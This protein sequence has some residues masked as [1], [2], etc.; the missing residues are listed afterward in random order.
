[1]AEN[2]AP[3]LWRQLQLTARVVHQIGQGR[4][5]TASLEDV[6]VG[7]RPGVQA[8][9]FAVL[10]SLGVAQS[11]LK[12]LAKR[13]PPAQATAL[14][15]TALA[16]LCQRE[17]AMYDAFTLVNQAVEAAKNTPAIKLQASFINACL[18]K[19]LRERDFFMVQV[20]A[21]GAAHWNHPTW[22]IAQL[23]RDWPD[24]W[25]PILAAN[26]RQAPLTLRVN[27]RRISRE[28]YLEKLAVA[29]LEARLVCES[30]LE[31]NQAVGVH[32]LP[33]FGEGWVS[34]Q[35]S[36]AQL[37]A[38]LLLAGRKTQESFR[39]IGRAHV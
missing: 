34:V 27:T 8:L 35:D 7:M 13:A 10:R 36:A 37:A 17:G 31:L 25:Q 19:F 6:A 3:P 11:L 33:G 21:D 30:G 22:W 2:C 20:E 16:L 23:Q 18:R 9:S 24:Q 15:C 5:G 28:A 12:L 4:S 39:E 29:G 1:M 14:L 32:E 38:P 26:N